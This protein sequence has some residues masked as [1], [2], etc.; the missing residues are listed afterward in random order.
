LFEKPDDGVVAWWFLIILAIPTIEAASKPVV[1]N[2]LGC[3][4]P[5]NKLS[6]NELGY[7]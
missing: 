4:L 6:I 5:F 1:I 2:P 7:V 3:G